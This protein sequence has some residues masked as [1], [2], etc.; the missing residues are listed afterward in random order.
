MDTPALV[1]IVLSVIT[2]IVWADSWIL[3]SADDREDQPEQRTTPLYHGQ[4]MLGVEEF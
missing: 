4:E 1:I 2:A 3:G